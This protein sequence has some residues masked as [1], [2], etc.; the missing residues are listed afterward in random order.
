MHPNHLDTAILLFSRSA[1]EESVVKPLI[2]RN[3]PAKKAVAAELIRHTRQIAKR[4]GLQLFLLSERRQH[5]ANFGERF[6]DAF[7]QLFALGFE[8]VISIGNDC[9]SL[10]AQDLI[11][12]AERLSTVSFV[13]GPAAD[14]GAYL[15]GMRR[16]MYNRERF[17]QIRWQT[18]GVLQDLKNVSEGDYFCLTE[19]Y[20]LDSASDLAR[21]FR[22]GQLPTQLHLRL[23]FYL[24]WRSQCVPDPRRLSFPTVFTRCSTSRGPPHFSTV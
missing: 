10:S 3:L 14:G 20:D 21:A 11:I 8:R 1:A 6:A 5:G 4:S 12:A 22:T 9:P 17:Q 18:A 23:S 16:E 2:A 19:K 13:F 15:I 7:E 24:K